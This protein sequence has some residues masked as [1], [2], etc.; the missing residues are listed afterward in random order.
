M[1][2][3]PDPPYWFYVLLPYIIYVMQSGRFS[4]SPAFLSRMAKE[5]DEKYSVNHQPQEYNLS[6]KKF[7]QIFRTMYL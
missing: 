5:R 4:Q 7:L 3:D 6:M 2:A 1:K